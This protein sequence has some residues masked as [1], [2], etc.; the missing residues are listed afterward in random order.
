[1]NKKQ[2]L[3]YNSDIWTLAIWKYTKKSYPEWDAP[4]TPQDG[5]SLEEKYEQVDYYSDETIRNI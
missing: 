4:L 3:E 1:M 5:I 2:Q